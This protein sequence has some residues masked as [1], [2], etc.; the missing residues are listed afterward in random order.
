MPLSLNPF[1]QSPITRVRWIPDIASEL[2]PRFQQRAID[3]DLVARARAD[4][5][6]NRP[7]K[8]D[9]ELD[10]AQRDVGTVVVEGINLLRQFLRDQLHRAKE[11]I[12]A[13]F[14]A[15]LILMYQ[16]SKPELP[17]KRPS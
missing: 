3:L 13:R 1:A 2:L 5:V 4:G 15:R 9:P 17:S 10:A 16:C 12:L 11:Q 6:E 8:D 14:P 7:D